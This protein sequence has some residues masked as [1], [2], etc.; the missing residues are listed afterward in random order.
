MAS[1]GSSSQCCGSVRVSPCADVELVIINIVQEHI[2][3]AEVV[4]GD[5]DLLAEKAQPHVLLAEYLGK[6]QAAGSRNR[7]QGHRPC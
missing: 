7:R 1:K 3:T 4:S 6:L 5:V 2:D